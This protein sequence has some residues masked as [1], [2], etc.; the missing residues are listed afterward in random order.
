MRVPAFRPRVWRA[1]RS[2]ATCRWLRERSVLTALGAA[3]LLSSQALAQGTPEDARKPAIDINAVQPAPGQPPAEPAPGESLDAPPGTATE[4]D[5]GRYPVSR[6][7]IEYHSEHP[8][9]PSIDDLMEAVVRLGVTPDGYV[10][11]REGMPSAELRIADVVEGT[12]G[13]FY[14]SALNSVARAIV[15]RLNRKG[16]IGIFVQLH[17][18]DIDETNGAD[19][20]AGKRPELRLVVWTGVV[21]NVRTIT[22][23][24]RLKKEVDAGLVDR[25]NTD[26]P[27]LN[28]IRDQSPLQ[29][30]NLL[31]KDLMDDFVFRLNRHPG[32]R[33]DV[34]IS[35]GENPEEVVVDYLVSE[36]KP[37]SIY[38]QLSNTGTKAT[39]QWRERFGFVHNQ[40]TGHDDV[41]R[42][43]YITGGFQD[44]HSVA[45]NYEFPL[46]SDRLRL[47]TYGAF[48]TFEAS[49]VG[50]SD[51]SF[52]GTTFSAGAEL[53]GTIFQHRELFID[54]VGGIRWENIHVENETFVTEARENFVIPYVGL[55][56]DRATEAA[57]T[58]ATVTMEFQVPELAGTDEDEID[59]L[60]RPEVDD[61]WQ[62]L[63]FSFEQSFYLEPL[64]NPGG[65][66]GRSA[67]GPLTLAHEIAFSARGQWA[68]GARLIPNEEEVAGGF[69]S[70][71]G[72]PESV[73]AGDNTVI[74]SLEYRFH[75]PRVFPVSDPGTLFGREVG[76]LGKDFR[77]APQQPFGRA[78]WDLVF[79]AFIDAAR[80]E[81]NDPQPGENDHTLVGAGLGI[82]YQF[83]RNVS[84]RL[85]Y[86]FPFEVVRDESENVD[87]GDGRW[88]FSLT[89]LY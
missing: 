85:E 67:R 3:A 39:N 61:H 75:L 17:P 29:V 78:D 34:A 73:V 6:F 40:L 68:F 44:S 87:V 84:A 26:D 59:F 62:V 86:G 27:V 80:T 56:L 24:D 31:R 10:A 5:G 55:R 36:A 37:W 52:S 8:E 65:Y 7:L 48:A 74:A 33:V 47:R 72:Y 18:D 46:L 71:R 21:K 79:K 28:R 16:F 14:R 4:R 25:V 32:R 13:V 11:Y 49:E 38:A 69:F 41:L 53:S 20:R 89:L 2:G 60:G 57:T 9:H 35:P 23:G 1:P 83:K 66:S 51:E 12:G 76:F 30:D 22:S 19:L 50:L 81:N 77:Y 43:D 45:V 70:V 54:A 88:H 58:Y 42:V 63:K 15:E 82:E 64:F